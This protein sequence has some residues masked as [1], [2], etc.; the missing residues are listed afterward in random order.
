MSVAMRLGASLLSRLGVQ[1]EEGQIDG[2]S[3]KR[4]QF[5]SWLTPVGPTA[6]WEDR[7]SAFSLPWRPGALAIYQPSRQGEFLAFTGRA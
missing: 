7:I 2:T 1:A 3:L 4:T 5:T 6:C